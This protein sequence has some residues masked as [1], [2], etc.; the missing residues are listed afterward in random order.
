MHRARVGTAC[1]DPNA[2]VHTRR[3]PGPDTH[4]SSAWLVHGLW[5]WVTA[6]GVETA[7]QLCMLR[8]RGCQKAWDTLCRP[9]PADLLTAEIV[10]PI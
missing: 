9:E 7:E 3:V 4:A 5:R 6:E 8:D 10:D 2:L 1:L